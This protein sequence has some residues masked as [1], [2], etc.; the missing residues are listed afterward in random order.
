MRI[1]E[2]QFEWDQP[3]DMAFA[4]PAEIHVYHVDL[5]H[6]AWIGHHAFCLCAEERARSKRFHF[7]RDQVNFVYT[8]AALRHVLALYFGCDPAEIEYD[9]GQFGKP[10]VD[11]IHFNLSHTKSRAAIAVSS[12]HPVGIDI[13]ELRQVDRADQIAGRYFCPREAELI[14][15]TAEPEKSRVFLQIWTLKEAWLKALGTG[16]SK[17]LNEVDT[18]Y[19]ATVLDELQCLTVPNGLAALCLLGDLVAE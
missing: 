14:R 17:P 7:E 5:E 4:D 15:A 18:G 2:H 9:I 1:R 3:L 12:Q 13:E 19:G 8:R 10:A 11:G 16:L 6:A